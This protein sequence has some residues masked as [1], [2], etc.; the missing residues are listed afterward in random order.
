MKYIMKETHTA[1][2]E[3]QAVTNSTRP[4][5]LPRVADTIYDN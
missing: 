5:R 4:Q 1:I 3:G 2:N